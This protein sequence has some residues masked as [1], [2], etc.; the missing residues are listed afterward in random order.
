LVSSNLSS[1]REVQ[2]YHNRK[3]TTQHAFSIIPIKHLQKFS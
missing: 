3:A 1:G 2:N